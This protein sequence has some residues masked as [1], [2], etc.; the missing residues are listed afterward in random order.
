MVVMLYV[1][2]VGIIML[3]VVVL[4]FFIIIKDINF[5]YF[6]WFM[7]RLVSGSGLKICCFLCLNRKY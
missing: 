5:V 2:R 6:I 1:C 4:V 3:N 7:V